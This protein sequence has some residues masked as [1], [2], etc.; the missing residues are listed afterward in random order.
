[1]KE[2][3]YA[4]IDTQNINMS[5]KE[6]GWKLDWKRFRI[7]LNDKYKINKAYLF[8]GYIPG[9]Q[10]LY[11]FLQEA[12]FI[13]VFKDVLELKSGKIKGNVDAELVL[14]TM[15]HIGK[16]DKATII[17]GDGDF[18]CLIKHLIKESKLKKLIVPNK[19]K[20]SVFLRKAGKEKIDSITNFRQ[21]VEYKKRAH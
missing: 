15:I 12:G 16:Y 2:N 10:E 8:L 14:E 9:N 17:S 6:Q 1:M 20:Y 19:D 18:A 13:I 11:N 3:N 7:Y 5:L 4:F 21:K